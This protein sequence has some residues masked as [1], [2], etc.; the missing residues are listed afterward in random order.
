MAKEDYALLIGI[1]SYPKLGEGGTPAN[2]RSPANDVASVKA[3]LVD[4]NG[5]NVP[6][7]HVTA[8]VSPDGAETPTGDQLEAELLKFMP[9][10]EFNKS[11]QRG[12]TVGRRIY[13]YMSGHGF[14]PLGVQ[15]ACLFT[16]NAYE[17]AG[18]N[19]H[20]TGWL[21]WL[22][23]AGFFREYVLWMD[24]CM[25]RITSFQ[26]RDPPF[27]QPLD[28]E[29]PLACFVAFAAQRP[30]RAVEAV[31][32][33]DGNK[34]HGVFTWALLEGLRGAAADRNGVV[35]G[36]SL[37]DW[38]R[39]AQV[40]RI[41]PTDINNVEV[42]KEPEVLREDPGLVFVRGVRKR[43]YDVAIS[44][45]ATA[46]GQSAR[47]WGG[48]PPVVR[49]TFSVTGAPEVLSLE[50]GLYL[51]DVPGAGLR[52]G[53]EVLGTMA[54]TVEST[55][56]AVPPPEMIDGRLF[57]LNLTSSETGAQIYVID[58]TFALADGGPAP[59]SPRL[60]FGLFKL[61]TKLPRAPSA[62]QVI[63]LDGTDATSGAMPAQTVPGPEPIAVPPVLGTST[64]HEYHWSARVDA[65]GLANVTALAQDEGVLVVMARTFSGRGGEERGTNT[66]PWRGFSIADAAGATV[67]DLETDSV[68]QSGG[69]PLATLV[70]K[71][72]AGS[73]FLRH[74]LDS[75]TLLEQS[76]IVCPGYR[77]EVYVLRRM[78]PGE[79][80]LA[81]RPRVSIVMR[82]HG[83]PVVPE[84]DR[85]IE[86]ARLALADE[87]RILNAELED[88][89]LRNFDSPMA[90]LIGGH[91]L[92]V[93]RDRD[94]YRDISLLG[95]AVDKLQAMIGSG[96]PD[97]AA[98]ALNCLDGTQRKVGTLTGPPLFQRSW[99][100]LTA[101][102][103]KRPKLIP[104]AMYERVLAMS[105]L[106][107]L[108]VWTADEAIKAGVRQALMSQ[109]STEEPGKPPAQAPRD[110]ALPD[111][112]V[113][114]DAVRAM[115]PGAADAA[116]KKARAT[117]RLAKQRLAQM[118]LPPSALDVLRREPK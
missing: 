104:A 68:H 61:K 97:V 36:R 110:A 73:Y 115:L 44:F 88:R 82:R 11:Q 112:R 53:F 14:V 13:L 52:Q 50:P 16:A 116:E 7:D 92:L 30:L 22:Q 83:E 118:N 55:G 100:L 99:V 42:S 63:M 96:H 33:E 67:M 31:I 58:N 12:F 84:E 38:I 26:P 2:L 93:E 3:W 101:A 90:G 105:A 20:A 80:K 107:P 25:E 70:R 77:H 10:A 102:A 49:K 64:S 4:P 56:A 28:V 62:Q 5:G 117:T 15:R 51:V 47:L 65:I 8:I 69:D 29:P 23:E 17:F 39:N 114:V 74:R 106:P 24:C 66:E 35:S 60:P 71:L 72:K 59:L 78:L 75:G 95:A 18:Y 113:D 108:L 103:Q 32:P 40:A 21:N 34:V 57:D 94:P 43:T 85:M 79:D 19:V 54:L 109:M 76:L 91:L 9:I 45:P 81:E 111:A 89:L 86:T 27:R 48:A 98:L 41:G 37:A 46:T 1:G 87:R 6:E